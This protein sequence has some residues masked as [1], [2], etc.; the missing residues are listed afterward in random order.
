M[1]RFLT[2]GIIVIIVA[3]I[4]YFLFIYY[5]PYSEGYRAGELVKISK[6]GLAFKTWEGSL[7]QGVS[8]SQHFE[9]SVQGKET[10]VLEQLK[11]LQGQQVK[12]TY[13]ER[14]GTFPWLGDTNYFITAVE[15]SDL[16]K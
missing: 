7:S 10:L 11:E 8:E 12:L 2:I 14:F 6:K 9:F 5:V 1:K 13:I 3:F 16:N 4:G 15:K